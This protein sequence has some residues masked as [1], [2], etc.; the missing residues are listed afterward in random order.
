MTGGNKPDYRYVA[1]AT[2]LKSLFH[3]TSIKNMHPFFDFQ[4]PYQIFHLHAD[5]MIRVP[6]TEMV[7]PESALFEQTSEL[8]ARGFGAFWKIE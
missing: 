6:D 4:K 3:T 8:F 2:K 5:I 1:I 7:E